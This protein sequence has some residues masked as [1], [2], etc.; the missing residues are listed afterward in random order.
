[1]SSTPLEDRLSR[2]YCSRM[3]NR[4][5]AHRKRA[6]RKFNRSRSDSGE[7]ADE[8]VVGEALRRELVKLLDRQ[9]DSE[10]RNDTVIPQLRFY[11]YSQPIESASILM[12]PAVYVVVQ[13]R[14]RVTVG[15]E[16]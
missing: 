6:A 11:R 13:G 14:K 16:V 7:G 8:V 1:Y 10:G 9:T 12:E 2:H 3:A 4:S 15:D 5:S